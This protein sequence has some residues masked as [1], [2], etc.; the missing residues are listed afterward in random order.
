V[1]HGSASK[2]QRR[3]GRRQPRIC[4][5]FD[6]P[7]CSCHPP[8]RALCRRKPSSR[9]SGRPGGGLS[10]RDVPPGLARW[11][12]CA[13]PVVGGWQARAVA[14]IP[15]RHQHTGFDCGI[16][17][18]LYAEKAAQGMLRQD[19]AAGTDQASIT[20]FRE[21]LRLYFDATRLGATTCV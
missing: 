6:P 2:G 13:C 21:L 1:S 3:H 7:S 18:L 12:D 10:N 4:P 5:P 15:H 14:A 19:I 17:C 20:E 11:L 9:S 8:S 16:A